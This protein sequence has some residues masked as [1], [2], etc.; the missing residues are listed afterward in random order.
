MHLTK[1]ALQALFF[2]ANP[3]H[4]DRAD[5]ENSSHGLFWREWAKTQVTG[6]VLRLV[7]VVALRDFVSVPWA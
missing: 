7:R 6:A 1:Q 2:V 5:L 3:F 4:V